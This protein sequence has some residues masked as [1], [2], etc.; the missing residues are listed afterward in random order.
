MSH[1]KPDVQGR[2]SVWFVVIVAVFTTCLI[3]ANIT[4]V[5]LISVLGFIVP[6]GVIIFPISYI[7]GDVLTEVYGYSKARRVIWL[8]FSV[9][10]LSLL[11]FILRRFC[12][13]L[14]SGMRRRHMN[15]Y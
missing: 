4:A 5:K 14:Q 7:F 10:C 6:A 11:R 1:S 12:L 8:G 9:T 3:S 13:L 15:A 2:Y